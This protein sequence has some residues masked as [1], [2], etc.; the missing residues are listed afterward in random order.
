[1]DFYVLNIEVTTQLGIA[2]LE[3]DEIK[4]MKDKGRV[5]NLYDLDGLDKLEGTIRYCSYKMGN[6]WQA[7]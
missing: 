4:V 3:K 2:S 5:K 6:T 1:M 7:I